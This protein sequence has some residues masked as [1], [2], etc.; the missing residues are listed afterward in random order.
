MSA[1][2]AGVLLRLAGHRADEHGALVQTPDA[3][4]LSSDVGHRCFARNDF[5]DPDVMFSAPCSGD[6]TAG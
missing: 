5:S 2:R 1:G 3:G 4:C 6:F